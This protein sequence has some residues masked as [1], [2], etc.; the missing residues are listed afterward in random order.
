VLLIDKRAPQPVETVIPAIIIDNGSST[1]KVGFAGEKAPK[2]VI[3]T[4]VGFDKG[5]TR[6]MF[7]VERKDY[8]VGDEVK[9]GYITGYLQLSHPVQ[10]GI[11]TN[12]DD[13]EKIWRHIYFQEL[14]VAPEEHPVFMTEAPL[15][16]RASK[17][18]IAEIFFEKFMAPSLYVHNT[19]TLILYSAG[20]TS[21]CVISI[22][23]SVS[24]CAPVHNGIVQQNAVER[25]N[26]G[27]KALTDYLR[28]RLLPELGHYLDTSEADVVKKLKEKYGFVAQEYEAEL[29][30]TTE[31]SILD[32]IY[33]L[34]DGNTVVVGSERFTCAEVLF[35]PTIMGKLETGLHESAYKAI[36]RCD[37]SIRGD[38]F[39]NIILAGGSSLFPGMADRFAKEF[40]AFAPPNTTMNVIAPPSREHSAWVGGATVAS[41]P[42]FKQS[43]ITREEYKE[44]GPN[45]VYKKCIN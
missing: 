17:L 1:V 41:L 38:I 22:G 39:S 12:W 8:Y 9:S 6:R 14:R 13:M 2:M 20:V 28:T 35:N 10:N 32:E 5:Q 34:P 44:Y 15:N 26:W 37:E 24:Y 29:H 42:A 31:S 21:G 40:A 18:K 19:A 36:M 30:A 33:E 25:R 27:G 23:D 11:V 16:P 43:F 45:I 4:V 7:G 3:P